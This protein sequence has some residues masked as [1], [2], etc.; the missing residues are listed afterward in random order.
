MKSSK[1][2]ALMLSLALLAALLTGCGSGSGAGTDPGGG[3]SGGSAPAS[4]QEEI[5]YTPES[6]LIWRLNSNQGEAE[7]A[8]CAQGQAYLHLA[9]ELERRTDGA[10]KIEFY[11]NS[12][13]GSSASELVNG[14]QFGAFE[15]FNLICSSWGEFSNAFLPLNTPCLFTDEEVLIE[16]LRGDEADVMS[17][18]LLADTGVRVAFYCPLGFR[19]TY[20]NIH[21]IYT[22]DDFKGVKM[23]TMTDPY[24]LGAFEAFGASSLNIPYAELYTSLDQGLADGADNPYA[25]IYNA[26]HYEVTRYLSDTRCFYCCTN[27][28]VAGAAYDALPEEWRTMFD[29]VCGE[30]FEIAAGNSTSDNTREALDFLK[31]HMEYND[32]SAEQMKLFEDATAG[33]REKAAAEMGR[34][35]WDRI[36]AEIERIKTQL[37]K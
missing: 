31:A 3:D 16:F 21:P 20:N 30:C 33:L 13:L 9:E 23:R 27:L 15:L 24:V 8:A 22:P 2:I 1:F 14:A 35:K 4:G 25:N 29:E 10:W 6:P 36:T 19:A 7:T 32:V 11:Y 26:K 28:C 18:Q 37:G 12:Q 17:E 34:E 5:P